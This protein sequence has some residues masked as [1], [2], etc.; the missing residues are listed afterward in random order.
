M[1]TISENQDAAPSPETTYRMS[2]GDTFEGSLSTYEDIDWI[3]IELAGGTAGTISLS[4]PGTRPPPY[5]LKLLIY[6][7]QEKSIA[8]FVVW[9]NHPEPSGTFDYTLLDNS[10]G[11]YYIGILPP[12]EGTGG[13]LG[14]SYKVTVTALE[15][16]TLGGTITGT[17]DYEAELLY[18][19]EDGERIEGR[20]GHDSLY[21][22]GGDDE[23]YGGDD[24]DLLHGGPGA[25]VLS[26]GD[27][28]DAA[29]YSYSDAGVTIRLHSLDTPPSGGHAEGDT[30]TK[31]ITVYGVES[32]DIENLGGSDYADILAGDARNNYLGGGGGDDTLYGGP[33]GGNDWL[34]GGD[35]DDRL[36]GGKDNDRLY[37]G[38]GNDRLYGGDDNDGLYGGDGIDELHGG[39]GND[40]LSGDAGDD[41]LEGGDGSDWLEGGDG[42]DRLE[43]GAGIDELYGGEGNDTLDAGDGG[44]DQ[45]HGGP[46]A[47]ELSGGDGY[48]TAYYTSS[49]AGVTVRLH[50]TNPARGGDAEGDTFKTIT[51]NGIELS[52][53]ENL[54]GSDYADI[55]AGDAN[56][57]FLY[58]LGGDDTLYGGPGGGDDWLYG[59]DGDD[60]LYG[61]IGNDTL[62]GGDGND[63][64]YGGATNDTLHG[65]D[66]D[67][68][69]DG[70]TGN[71]RLSGGDGDNTLYGGEGNDRLGGGN[72]DDTL[73]GGIGNDTVYGGIGNDTVYGGDGNDWL[74]GDGN[75]T[76]YGGDGNDTLYGDGGGSNEFLGEDGGATLYGDDGDDLLY[77][78][79]HGGNTLYG[80]DGDDR[81]YGYGRAGTDTLEG[82]D[83]VD[84]F[85]FSISSSDG[86]NI[87]TDFS[88]DAAAR[89]KLNL[90]SR[91][92]TQDELVA[93]ITLTDGHVSID[94]TPFG[95]GT[96]VLQSVTDLDELEAPGGADND[97]I[98]SLSIAVDANH[99]GDYTDPG[100]TDGIFIL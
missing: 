99:D 22:G 33:G 57:N 91:N 37:G 4:F 61:G 48:D 46:G 12:S 6:S 100:D 3:G 42:N 44:R 69:L 83:G 90:P 1:A 10:L 97:M 28:V 11:P 77:S 68:L 85:V 45:L 17:Y 94:L 40:F 15:A 30:F 35:G 96:I 39:D 95:G 80:G 71:D 66:G 93:S 82:G 76:V 18:G 79:A 63:R 81:L 2:V 31:I 60:R 64:L 7:A 32:Y 98:D 87:I 62:W 88:T 23:L 78:R 72:G 54:H 8:G 41:T 47:D 56:N 53:I 29:S 9:N 20:G 50:S 49:N 75:D 73:Y 27:G 26:G 59:H 89:D 19:T 51:V 13:V 36:Y 38:D 14:T 16:P 86:I 5:Y 25:D 43:G 24:N 55:L 74:G 58:G 34:E 52:D 70:G 84:T 67:D 65:G 92:V 21:G